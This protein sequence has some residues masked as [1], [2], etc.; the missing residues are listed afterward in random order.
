[1]P[2]R[3]FN[4]HTGGWTL[5]RSSLEKSVAEFPQLAP[6]KAEL[7]A[8]LAEV[9]GRKERVA[10]LKG[11]LGHEAKLLRDTIER[12]KV[13]ESRVRAGVKSAYG[14]HSLEL[15]RHGMRPVRKKR[16]AGEGKPAETK[17]AGKAP[18]EPSEKS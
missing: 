16:V 9:Q 17:P 14:P 1:M 11:E 8:L 4:E 12:G 3:S 10:K 6:L 7:E 18:P 5:L 2:R 15:V 13:L